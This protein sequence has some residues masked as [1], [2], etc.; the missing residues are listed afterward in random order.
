MSDDSFDFDFYEED[1]DSP[2]KVRI[3][4][5]VGRSSS[6]SE[7]ERTLKSKVPEPFKVKGVIPLEQDQEAKNFIAYVDPGSSWMEVSD[8]DYQALFKAL[9]EDGMYGVELHESVPE[10]I[11]FVSENYKDRMYAPFKKPISASEIV[12]RDI[13]M[14]LIATGE[15]GITR[16]LL[17]GKLPVVVIVHGVE[18]Q[19][20]A[21]DTVVTPYAI[22]VNEELGARLSIPFNSTYDK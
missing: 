11:K 18:G 12:Q 7:F 8:E 15:T 3:F 4:T 19:G 20:E 5:I 13:M 17:D 16:G 14:G 9:T 6:P 22:M 1:E 2:P 21:K 10:A